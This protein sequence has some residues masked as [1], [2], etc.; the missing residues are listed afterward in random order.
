MSVNR[1]VESQLQ[2]SCCMQATRHS[3][4]GLLSC[5]FGLYAR[6]TLERLV[7]LVNG[8]SY[9]QQQIILWIHG[10][11]FSIYYYAVGETQ[12]ARAKGTDCLTGSWNDTFAHAHNQTHGAHGHRNQLSGWYWIKR[13]TAS[14]WCGGIIEVHVFNEFAFHSRLCLCVAVEWR[15]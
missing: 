1:V 9:S 13:S 10:W 14:V 5:A 15:E 8:S 2:H 7:A 6:D 3:N 11:H 12:R 4:I